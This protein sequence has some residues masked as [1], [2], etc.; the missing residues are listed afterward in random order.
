MPG[1]GRQT[2]SGA[3]VE[4]TLAAGRGGGAGPSGPGG[5]RLMRSAGTVGGL[6]LVSRVFGY[7]RDAIVS[8]LLGTSDVA[9][10]FGAAY[11]FPNTLRRLASEG[12]LAAAFVPVF[13]S[14]EGRRGADVWSF[15][16]RFQ[17]GVAVV[18]A[19]AT[20]VG[21][22]TAHWLVPLVYEG[23]ADTPGKL[24]LTIDLTR[25]LFG[26]AF[27]ISL[28]AVLMA[29]LNARD[30]FGAAAFTPVLLNVAI[31]AAGIGAWAYGAPRPVYWIVGGVI[32]GGA[33]Q[34]LFLVPFA[35]R[36]GMPFRPRFDLADP[37]VRAVGRLILP[38]MLGV[39]VVQL[40]ILVGQVL[41][42]GLGEGA[43]ISLYY[44]ARVQE[45]TLGVFAV[46]VAT[47]VL[48]TLSRQG[49]AADLPAMRRTLTF[50]LRQVTAI[51]LPAAVGILLLRGDIVAVLFE[52]GR[53][54]ADST[55]LTA[56]ALA[57]YAVGLSAVAAV[58][59]LAPGFY[60]LHDTRTPV[61]VA[62]AG[63]AVNLVAALALRGPLGNG[64]IALANS[65]AAVVGAALLLSLLRRRLRRLE[66]RQLLSSF[67]RVGLASA[68]MGLVVI[69]IPSPFALDASGVA[70]APDL[71]WRI[72][73]GVLVYGGALALLGA[74]EISELRALVRR[75]TPATLERGGDRKTGGGAGTDS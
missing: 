15:A 74:P 69:F 1:S 3:A 40:N 73:V 63:V 57:G 62:L 39:G 33:A 75:R 20:A 24:D 43:V 19:A 31:I 13:S 60:A 37:D 67:L 48:P 11:L 61:M 41:A 71:I 49:A 28:S 23:Y 27:F 46:S 64:G 55:A 44:A 56:T 14:V 18:V 4:D 47:V 7:L 22:L 38:R 45:L 72:L 50:A 8:A 65:L 66:G 12:N 10:A 59:V 52:R 35:R 42:A 29:V 51:T 2:P 26:Y 54:D 5:R 6:T 30:R 68:A 36:I 58:R 25:L 9:D 70:G 34:W 17:T 53:F 16:A 21:V 32:A